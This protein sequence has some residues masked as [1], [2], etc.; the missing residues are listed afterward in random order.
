[1]GWQTLSIHSFETR[2]TREL[3]LKLKFFDRPRWSPDGRFILVT[4]Q[5]RQS[6]QGLYRIDVASGEQTALA[7]STGNTRHA[8]PAWSADGKAVIFQHY[9]YVAS[10]TTLVSKEVATG[11]ETELFRAAKVLNTT[12]LAPAPD[13]RQLAFV[14]YDQAAKTSTVKLIPLSGGAARDL[15]VQP[16]DPKDPFF[17]YGVVWTPDAREL[18]LLKASGK[19][20]ESEAEIWRLPTTG[21]AP[22]KLTLAMERVRE[23]RLHPDGKRIAFTSGSQKVEVWVLE[24]LPAPLPAKR[25][26]VSRR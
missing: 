2:K 5:D 18:L 8:Q 11:R 3:R 16:H 23:L 9:D 24:N 4:G 1:M 10:L 21:G 19:N 25:N 7:Q 13:G 6:L 26:A 12:F 17:F 14:V 22:Q 20:E 15:L